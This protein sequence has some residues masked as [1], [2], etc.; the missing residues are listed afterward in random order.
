MQVKTTHVYA[1][2][3]TNARLT[4]TADQHWVDS[5]AKAQC[6][7]YFVVVVVPNVDNGGEWI[8]HHPAGTE[9]VGTAAY[10][11]RID[12]TSFSPENMSVAALRS[13]RLNADTVVAWQRDLVDGYSA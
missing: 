2:D 13:Q 6:P 1:V 12:P 8:A 10:W 11:S 4:Y 5:W 9:M 3:G 7:V